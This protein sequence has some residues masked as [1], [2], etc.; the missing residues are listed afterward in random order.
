[1]ETVTQAEATASTK[2]QRQQRGQHEN[3]RPWAGLPGLQSTVRNGGGFSDSGGGV[4][5]SELGLGKGES[6]TALL[7]TGHGAEAQPD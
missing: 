4:G 1:M 7:G 5:S 6:D 2:V 3:E